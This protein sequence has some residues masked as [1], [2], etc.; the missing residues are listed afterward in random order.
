MRLQRDVFQQLVH[1]Q[2]KEN[3]EEVLF[4]VIACLSFS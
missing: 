2:A 3:T 1:S 4:D